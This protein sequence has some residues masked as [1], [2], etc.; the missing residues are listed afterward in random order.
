MKNLLILGSTGSIGRQALSLIEDTALSERYVV[1]GLTAYGKNV[2]TVVEQVG[3]FKPKRLAVYS[4]SV[5]TEL[6]QLLGPKAEVL[7][8]DEGVEALSKDPQV[9]VVLSGIAGTAALKPTFAAVKAG[10]TIALAN[11]ES[12]VSMGALMT[13]AAR[14]SGAR[15]VPVDSEH[16]A[17]FQALHGLDNTGVQRLTLTASGGPFRT[18]PLENLRYVKPREAL[19]HPNWHMGPLVTVNSA[20]LM[21]KGQE[22]IE[23][24]WLFG[25]P[26]ARIEALIH[27]QSIIHSLV[28]FVD[29]SVLAQLSWPDMR[30]PILYA[31]TYPDRIETPCRPLD[32]AEVKQL[33][34]EEI[35]PVRYPCYALARATAQRGGLFPAVMNAAN[36]VAVSLFLEEKTSFLEI[37]SLVERTLDAF[38][39]ANFRTFD[40]DAVFAADHW[41]RFKVLEFARALAA[42]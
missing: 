5:A 40:L 2:E 6:K 34:F 33:T 19:E 17:I 16:S 20:T 23:A 38:E 8:G 4:R 12:L 18:L 35:D 28:E 3:R 14:E 11:K 27:P 37:S 9:D 29:K 7:W 30:I 13:T 26:Y 10:K 21:N 15:L 31:L 32:L 41:A 36:E 22:I 42:V 25:I 39:S 24:H 1:Y